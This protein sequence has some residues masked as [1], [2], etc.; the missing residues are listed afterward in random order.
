[1]LLLILFVATTTH[2]GAFAVNGVTFGYR[3]KHTLTNSLAAVLSNYPTKIIVN[4][5]AGA[6]GGGTVYCNSKCKTDFGDV[7]FTSSDGVT[8]ID[9]WLEYKVDSTSAIF[10]VEVPSFA[11]STTTDIFM[12]YGN[13]SKTTS[14]NGTNT[15]DFFDDFADGS[16]SAS[17]TRHNYNGWTEA[18]GVLT[19]QTAGTTASDPNT[20]NITNKAYGYGYEIR[21]KLRIRQWQDHDYSRGGYGLI[22]NTSG[23]G[24]KGLYHWAT[25]KN[26]AILHDTVVWLSQSNFAWTLNT[27]Y[28][29]SFF[30]SLN[31]T[32]RTLELKDWATGAA[33][34][35]A[36]TI[37]ITSTNATNQG[38]EPCIAGSSIPGGGFTTQFI[39]DY[40]D[41][42]IR[43]RASTEP[44]HTSWGTEENSADDFFQFIY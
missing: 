5:G 15:F 22:T 2:A 10:W 17:Y 1:V 18:G 6:D 39:G 40:D 7:T 41:V 12:Y 16:I 24:Y 30:A 25:N 26:R 4:Y 44:S 36:P 34:P 19:F 20:Q 43:Q 38:T 42:F 31:V 33:E 8:L 27:W 28:Q 37:T 29:F 13:S 35:G 32:T 3:K 21:G 9:Y 11:A 23:L 14:S